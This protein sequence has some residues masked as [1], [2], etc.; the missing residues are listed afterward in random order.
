MFNLALKLIRVFSPF[1]RI[2]PFP[3]DEESGEPICFGKYPLRHHIFTLFNHIKLCTVTYHCLKLHAFIIALT[4]NGNN[5]IHEYN[6][7][8]NQN[9]EPEYPC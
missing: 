1:K 8:Y 6:V 2:F 7:S 9:Q 4:D 5:E 3:D